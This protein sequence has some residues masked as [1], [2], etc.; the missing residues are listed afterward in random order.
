MAAEQP[1]ETP[2][3]FS[4]RATGLVRDSSV[5]NTASFNILNVTVAYA[6]LY[7][8]LFA[9]Q[10]PGSNLLLGGLLAVIAFIPLGICYAMLVAAMPRAGSDYV[11]VSRVL[12]P[13]L[14]FVV[15]MVFI[16]WV[17]F[18]SGL[19]INFFFTVGL[20][21]QMTTLGYPGAASFF[22]SENW[23]LF[24]GTVS[25]I[26]MATLTAVSTKRALQ[27]LTGLV[28][29]GMFGTLVTGIVLLTTSHSDFIHNF[30]TFAQP[31]SHSAD[32]Y[33][34]VTAAAS[35]AG[36]DSSH[37]FSLSATLYLIPW[38]ASSFIYLA[39]QAAIGGEI[40]RPARNSFLAM[41]MT[42]GVILG[43]V[44]LVFAGLN[45]AVTQGFVDSASFVTFNTTHWPLPNAPN[46]NFLAT[47]ATTSDTLR[48]VLSLCFAIW[49]LPG[50]ILNY[51]FISRYTVATT[52]DG[53]L[54][55]KLGEVNPRTH[56]PVLAIGIGC[57]LSIISLWLLTKDAN[58]TVILNAV[59]GE[60]AG[61]YLLVS[62]AAIFFP[63]VSRTKQAYRASPA[64]IEFLGVPVITIMGVLS[65]LVLL[66]I[67]YEFWTNGNYGLNTRDAKITTLAIPLAAIIIYAISRYVR[68]QRQQ[69][70][71]L[72]FKEI[73]P[74]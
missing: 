31:Y 2:T 6:I 30:N 67:G 53:V 74:A 43:L 62:I 72:A 7:P 19:G 49:Y 15:A 29:V 38:A 61:A 69:D 16:V 54:P 27:V 26:A 3:F 12:H 1:Q 9:W 45:L 50:P 8:A 44:L 40:K 73:P 55:E 28:V 59:L 51:I 36:F 11:F 60:L 13:A 46:Y 65:S 48:W 17:S 5:W 25:L 18:W 14:G 63:Y 32:T 10:F 64:N 58:I 20:A 41:Y 68:S 4:R 21:P 35:K 52:M 24:L 66:V 70:I 57:V 33:H 39:G 47:I 23:V 37:P 34:D 22:T 56:T 42:I 71:S